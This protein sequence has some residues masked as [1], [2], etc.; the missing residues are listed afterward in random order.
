MNAADSALVIAMLAV[1]LVGCHAKPKG[2]S[3]VANRGVTVLFEHFTYLGESSGQAG[4]GDLTR[5]SLYPNPVK[6]GQ[7]YLF[8]RQIDGRAEDMALDV[9]PSRLPS[10]GFAVLTGPKRDGTGFIFLDSGGPLFS[11]KASLGECVVLIQKPSAREVPGS[12]LG[13]WKGGVWE[14]GAYVLSVT[15]S[16]CHVL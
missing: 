8:N 13:L 12:S 16:G 15:G 10:L 14:A 2:I 3:R 1:S 6:V 11:I 9:I 4:R 7:T 5:T